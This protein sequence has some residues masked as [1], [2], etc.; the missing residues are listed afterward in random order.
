[1]HFIRSV[2]VTATLLAFSSLVLATDSA[3]KTHVESIKGT[4]V[5]ASRI[6]KLSDALLDD[7]NWKALAKMPSKDYAAFKTLYEGI[8]KLT[9]VNGIYKAVANVQE[10]T[11]EALETACGHFNTRATFVKTATNEAA[12]KAYTDTIYLVS[13][14]LYTLCCYCFYS[15]GF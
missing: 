10:A 12:V 13:Y 4:V 5:E 15:P 8:S 6:P 14:A 9:S 1:M 3:I 7:G 2:A 11:G